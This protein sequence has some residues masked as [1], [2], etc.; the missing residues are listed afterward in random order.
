M[1]EEILK[2]KPSV[3]VSKCSIHMK[4][5]EYFCSDCEC[6]ACED[7]R[8]KGPHHEETHRLVHLEQVI[9]LVYANQANFLGNDFQ[10]IRRVSNQLHS[11]MVRLMHYNKAQ[12]Q[13]VKSETVK[14]CLFF[15]MFY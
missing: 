15:F 6:L 13:T 8:N 3:G 1:N 9:G 11:E 10:K 4:D 5:Y 12:C 2:N 7:C 14:Y